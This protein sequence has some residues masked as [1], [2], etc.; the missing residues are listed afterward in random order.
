[1]MGWVG[2]DGLKVNPSLP[3]HRMGFRFQLET[4]STHAVLSRGMM[5]VGGFET[6]SY[7]PM[8]FFATP[9]LCAVA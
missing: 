4:L 3:C 2:V 7:G 5:V 8:P 1:M 9:A 6:N